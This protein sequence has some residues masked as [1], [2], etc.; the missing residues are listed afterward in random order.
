MT[1]GLLTIRGKEVVR[2][3]S[4][5]DYNQS[6]IGVDSKDQLLHSYL[7]ERKRMNEWYMKLFHS[8]LNTSILNAMIIYRNNTGKRT[9]QLSFRI[10]SIEGLFVKYANPIERKVPGQ[11][12]SDN[13][14]LHLARF[15]WLWRN[16]DHRNGMF[17]KNVERER[18]LYWCDVGL[19]EEYFHDCH[20]QL[21]F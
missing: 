9:E 18:T 8:L 14:V 19:C 11:H 17:V 16:D 15:H 4:L 6:M 1:P 7:I 2:P 20:T 13:T 10:Q 3:L 21:N 12:S 5:L